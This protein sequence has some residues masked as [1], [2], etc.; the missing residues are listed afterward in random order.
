MTD[1]PVWTAAGAAFA[2]IYSH[3]LTDGS[4]RGHN[5]KKKKVESSVAISQLK[6]GELLSERA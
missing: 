5:M 1:I 6:K 4:H 3:Q 2:G